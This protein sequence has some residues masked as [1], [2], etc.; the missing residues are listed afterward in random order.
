[1]VKCN[2][3]N[4]KVWFC[5]WGIS[6]NGLKWI[7]VSARTREK[8]IWR[9]IENSYGTNWISLEMKM[10]KRNKNKLNNIFEDKIIYFYNLN[11]FETLN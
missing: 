9:R 10:N 5:L 1:M 4:W 7:E 8:S 2:R 6:S 3:Y 11:K